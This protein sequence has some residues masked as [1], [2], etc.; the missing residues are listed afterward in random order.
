MIILRYLF[1]YIII[2]SFSIFYADRFQKKTEKT[3]LHAFIS[4]ILLLYLFGMVNQLE[5]GVIIISLFS[6]LLFVYTVYQ[7]YKR[8]TFKELKEKTMTTGSI[9][10]TILFFVF[11]LTTVSRELTHWDQFTY[12]SIAT[13]D[14]F[15]TNH[16]L[17]GI[18][19]VTQYPPVP[20]IL[21][22][23]FMKVIG[24][25][26]QGI[27]IFTTWLLGISF[28]LPFFEK[29]N[30][31]KL[32]NWMIAILIL[33]VPAVFQMLIFYES[34][35]PDALLGII[36]GQ[37]SYLYF[38]EET[39]KF[40]TFSVLITFFL[41]TL[42]KPTGVVIALILWVTFILF[43]IVSKKNLK[44]TIKEM[45][46]SKELKILWIAF[47][48]IVV[49]YTSWML[50]RKVEDTK[51]QHMFSQVVRRQQDRKCHKKCFTYHIRN[52][53]RKFRHGRF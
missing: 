5:T 40:K 11:M 35:Y 27:E 42:T 33:C 45:I 19:N 21:Q 32:V 41:L 17:V 10:F 46:F 16:L 31:K 44:Q 34:S 48:V 28:F 38:T 26:S 14:M 22:Y 29:S 37:L 47:A 3:I 51:T 15:Y 39:G 50:Y 53:Y 7:N 18:Q 9:F 2:M 12:W 1:L 25:Y 13:K 24:Q 43:E 8:K 36:I 6:I 30:G 4:I 20:T 52:L 23:F 49:T